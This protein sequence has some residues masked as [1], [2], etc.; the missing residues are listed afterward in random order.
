MTSRW[1][2]CSSGT[3]NLRILYTQIIRHTGKR[4]TAKQQLFQRFL[5]NKQTLRYIPAGKP[6]LEKIVRLSP[7]PQKPLPAALAEGG[8][9]GPPRPRPL[10]EIL[11]GFLQ[12]PFHVIV[13]SKFRAFLLSSGAPLDPSLTACSVYSRGAQEE[14]NDHYEAGPPARAVAAATAATAVAAAAAAATLLTGSPELRGPV[15]GAHTD[16]QV[17]MSYQLQQKQQQQQQRQQQQQLQQ[18]QQPRHLEQPHRARSCSACSSSTQGPRRPRVQRGLQQSLRKGGPFPIEL[19]LQQPC[20]KLDPAVWSHMLCSLSNMLRRYQSSATQAV[21]EVEASEAANVREIRRAEE[22]LRKS[23]ERLRASHAERAFLLHEIAAT[24]NCLLGLEC[25]LKSALE[26]LSQAHVESENQPEAEGAEEL[27]GQDPLEAASELL[28]LSADVQKVQEA[29]AAAAEQVQKLRQQLL[30]LQQQKRREALAKRMQ[31][32]QQKHQQIQERQGQLQ[33][34]QYWWE[35]YGERQL[36]HEQRQAELLKQRHS[37]RRRS[38]GG[39]AAAP[40]PAAAA[41]GGPLLR[42]R[43]AD[44]RQQRR[45]QQRQQQQQQNG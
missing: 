29:H 20:E 14:P 32:V 4:Q 35:A 39:A 27:Q 23:R 24:T 1:Q 28:E 2:A 34:L 42:C 22:G 25:S 18:E 17:M 6:G 40:A 26:R 45:M 12:V 21:E 8:P 44:D 11:R 19:L 30:L 43:S 36:L 38:L 31:S 41:A 16:S 13:A 7:P 15:K 37:E 10:R 9:V 5:N 3:S 33:Q